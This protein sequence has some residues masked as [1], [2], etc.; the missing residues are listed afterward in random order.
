MTANSGLQPARVGVLPVRGH[1][2]KEGILKDCN[3]N[4]VNGDAKRPCTE[5]QGAGPL[6]ESNQQ[7]HM[8]FKRLLLETAPEAGAVPQPAKYLLSMHE[9]LNSNPLKATQ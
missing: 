5:E 6:R 4:K 2:N 9:D 1:K 7:G 3:Q 8:V